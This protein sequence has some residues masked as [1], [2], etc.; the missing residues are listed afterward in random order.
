MKL[1]PCTGKP[2]YAFMGSVRCGAKTRQGSPCKAPAIKNKVRCRMHGGKG[3]G[4][5]KGSQ[6]AFKNGLYTAKNMQLRKDIRDLLKESN[7][8]I[9]ELNK[10]MR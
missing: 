10:N 6:N 1:T 9:S 7:N 2:P 3:S 8:A 4:A 5:P